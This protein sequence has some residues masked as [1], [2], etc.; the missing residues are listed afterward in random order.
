LIKLP[1]IQEDLPGAFL[2]LY[3]ATQ[4]DRMTEAR[5]PLLELEWDSSRE[6]ARREETVHLEHGRT[7]VLP[8]MP[9]VGDTWAI[10]FL[11]EPGSLRPTVEHRWG[12]GDWTSNWHQGSILA[13]REA[14]WIQIRL[15]AQ[16][17]PVALGTPFTTDL[18]DTWVLTG[19][20]DAQD[21]VFVF[22]SPTGISHRRPAVYRERWRWSVE[23]VPDEVGPWRYRWFQRFTDTPYESPAGRFDVYGGEMDSVVAHLAELAEAVSGSAIDR[24]AAQ[25]RML[26]FE[27][28]GMR[29]LTPTSFRGKAGDSLRQA[30]TAVR[31]A[32]VQRPIPDPIPMVSHE[33]VEEMDGSKVT[34]PFPSG[35]SYGVW[36]TP[37][38]DGP[39]PSG[40]SSLASRLG[41]ALRRLVRNRSSGV[42][43]TSMSRPRPPKN[44]RHDG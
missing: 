2:S 25:R 11:P 15:R 40:S 18:S 26:A 7:M 30:L 37:S 16:V 39:R 14:E 38:P 5:R 1:D 19:P 6:V 27:R 35:T 21:V 13:E 33:L 24:F 36:L 32:I 31:S 44:D 10:S 34:E 12:R 22:T 28:E 3:S 41:R 42:G 29:L 23:F 4:G 17:N 9:S 8:R 43:V 20:P